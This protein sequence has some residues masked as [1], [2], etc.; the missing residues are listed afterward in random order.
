MQEGGWRKNS[1]DTR[2]HWLQG[3]LDDFQNHTGLEPHPSTTHWAG[4]A[5]DLPFLN[6]ENKRAT[7]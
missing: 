3:V 5:T 1:P 4:L 6:L 2:G 7:K